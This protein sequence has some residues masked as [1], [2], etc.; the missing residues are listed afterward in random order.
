M[1]QP[2]GAVVTVTAQVAVLLPFWVVTVIVA[3][4]C[5]TA[6][7]VPLATVA[8]F[9]LLLDQVTFLLVALAGNTVG[10]SVRVLPTLSVA[11]I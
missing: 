3:E 6:V 2:L 1:F 9:V 10:V 4:P 5:A 8:T 7:T 11:V